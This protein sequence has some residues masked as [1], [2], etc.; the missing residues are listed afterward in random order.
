MVSIENQRERKARHEA[1]HAAVALYLGM[2]GNDGI[3]V[4]D[5]KEQAGWV[6]IGWQLEQ[7]E[8][9]GSVKS[10]AIVAMAGIAAEPPG[11]RSE[12]AEEKINWV[13]ACGIYEDLRDDIQ[14]AR[15][16]DWVSRN[17]PR[18][19]TQQIKPYLIANPSA[20][21]DEIVKHFRSLAE[22]EQNAPYEMV[23]EH[24]MAA[25]QILRL[26]RPAGF[27]ERSSRLLKSEA[28]L[29]SAECRR[30]WDEDQ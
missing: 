29:T 15:C 13:T 12:L 27:V 11:L 22:Y 9:P 28:H 5:E 1:G 3:T 2:F 25:K 30:L 24:F 26:R 14:K 4:A 18:I 8:F 17:S 6:S 10:R 19:W 21:L 16:L 23:Q 20:G 7:L